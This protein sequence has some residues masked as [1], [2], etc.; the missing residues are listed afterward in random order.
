MALFLEACPA[1]IAAVTGTQGKS[2]TCHTLAQILA[3]S[4]FR[5]HL[6]GNIGGSLLDRSREMRAE[7][8]AVVEISS[9]QLEA[10]PEDLGDEA[11]PRVEVVA[12]TNVLADHIERHG[13]IEAYAAAKRLILRLAARVR[14]TAVLSAEDPRLS[15][16]SEPGLRRL[17]VFCVRASDSG[18]NF[19]DGRFRMDREVLGRLSDLKIPGVFQRENTLI[20]LGMARLLGADPERLASAIAGVRALPHRLEDLGSRCGHRV[21]DNGVSTTPDSTLSVLH[22]IAP[23]CTLLCGG[24]AKDLPLDELVQT[25]RGRVR[26]VVAFGSAADRFGSAFRAAGIE[27]WAAPTVESA[28]TTAFE[29]M[30]P[31]EELLFSPAAASFDAY[32]N[33]RERAIAFRNALPPPDAV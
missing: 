15:R 32:L 13:S 33:F 2:S 23:G 16:W 21:W 28:V 3:A 17:D 9:Y 5:V 6:G 20:A 10:L 31:G 30:E 22:S 14:G 26:R 18:L 7:D 27:T 8:V 11:T 12:V 24:K 25:A 19:S 1:R 4:G 29:R